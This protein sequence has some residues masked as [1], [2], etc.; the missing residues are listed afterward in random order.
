[1]IDNINEISNTD[2]TVTK[3]KPD[4][5][6]K[7]PVEKD[8]TVKAKVIQK[9]F[10]DQV[11]AEVLKSKISVPLQKNRIELTKNSPYKF[12]TDMLA[13]LRDSETIKNDLE[14]S[15]IMSDLKQ[16]I[17]RISAKP[18]AISSSFLK[19]FIG[20]SGMNWENKLKSM[21][22]SGPWQ[23]DKLNAMIKQDVKGL[24]LKLMKEIGDESI[25]KDNISK[26]I[27]GLD[28]L[29][30]L[31]STSLEE[32]GKLLF[33]IPMLFGN[34]FKFG[35]IFIDLSKKKK[36]KKNL[37]DKLITVSLLLEMTNMGPVRVDAQ[38]FQKTIKLDFWVS[39]EDVKS[40]INQ[41]YA[42]LKGQM[43]RHGFHLQSIG[44]HF[45]EKTELEQI[46]FVDEFVNKEHNFSLMV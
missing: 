41:N 18:G 28:T 39:D 17:S 10:F 23:P 40:L 32:D 46:S 5:D 21:L 12:L 11:K 31:N 19:S 33:M 22:F 1:M 24:S 42:S 16:I 26:F 36:D 7:L 3:E 29:Q 34:T 15:E 13:Q 38:I 37:K 25:F 44:C 4:T 9:N 20:G 30:L 43:E 14:L 2:T 27:D 6:K 8:E 35:Q 45:K